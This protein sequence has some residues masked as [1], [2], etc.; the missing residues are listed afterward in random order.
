MTG[1]LCTP[2]MQMFS[3]CPLEGELLTLAEL[4]V[5]TRV[6]NLDQEKAEIILNITLKPGADDAWLH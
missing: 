5:I 6:V 1:E 4:C 3:L 2:L